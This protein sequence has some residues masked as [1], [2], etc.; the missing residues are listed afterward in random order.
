MTSFFSFFTPAS[1]ACN[2]YVLLGKTP[3][4][5]TETLM[6]DLSNRIRELIVKSP[7]AHP[8]FFFDFDGTVI[9]GDV[10]EG[11]Q[12]EYS[13]LA[14]LAIEH[15]LA[16]EEYRGAAGVEKFWS[17]YHE[18]HARE[19]TKA[20]YVWTADQFANFTPGQRAQF[21]KIAADYWEK[22]LKNYL[23]DSSL[24]WIRAIQAQGGTVVVLSASPQV[25]VEAGAHFVGIPRDFFF[26]INRDQ[27]EKGQ[28]IN[29]IVTYAEGKVSQM[30][31]ILDRDP[32]AVVVGGFGNSW[33]TDGA[34]LKEVAMKHK[35]LSVMINGGGA[36]G[37]G[38]GIVEIVQK[39]RFGQKKPL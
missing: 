1:Q 25:F 14:S 37:E 19:G 5:A 26:G 38:H 13:G 28:W 7:Q 29:P 32:H 27:N 30:N 9:D 3:D 39:R 2:P 6:E 34:F 4:G 23:F 10:T 12:G 18:I 21:E 33:G 20:A 35:G 8:Y 11:L 17:K 36:P 31:E 15:G 24:Q 22:T 16:S